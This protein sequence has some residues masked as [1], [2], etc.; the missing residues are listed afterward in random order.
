M[1]M[2][3]LHDLAAQHGANVHPN[4]HVNMGQSSNDVI[5][6][7]IQVSACLETYE[8][9]LPALRHLHQVLIARAVDLKDVVKTGRTHLMDAMPVTFGQELNCWAQQIHS[10]I[11]RIEGSPQASEAIATGR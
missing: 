11:D 4:D 3:S 2:R 6:T 7:A 10:N 1:P 9:L 8:S 5:P